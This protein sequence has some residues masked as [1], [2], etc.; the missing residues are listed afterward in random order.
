MAHQP[1]EHW[2]YNS[3]SLILLSEI[4]SRATGLSVPRFA[5]NYLMAPLD[6]TGLR[7]GLSPK[8]RAWLGGNASM[9]PREMAKFGQMCLN[10]GLCKIDRSSQK[11][12]WPN[13]PV[14]MSIRNM[15]WNTV[16][17]GGGGG[18]QSMAAR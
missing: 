10:K 17:S 9:R 5:D 16:I 2:A 13:R 12:G 8:G 1:G 6:I 18:R 3:T 14:S 7:W 11:H 15:A 4:I